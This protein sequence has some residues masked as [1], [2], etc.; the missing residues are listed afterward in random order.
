M[1]VIAALL[2]LIPALS[3][4]SN[5]TRDQRW[6]DDLQFLQQ[7]ITATHPNP[8]TQISR[9]QF[10]ESVQQ[11]NDTIPQLSDGAVIAGLA[12]IAAS[13][14]DYHTSLSLTQG[15]AGFRFPPIRLRWFPDGLFVTQASD[16]HGPSIGKRVVQIGDK[17]AEDAYAAVRPYI[18]GENDWW[19]RLI[20]GNYLI[21]PDILL[22]AGVIAADGPVP[23]VFEDGTA[24]NVALAPAALLNGPVI[25]KPLFPYYRRNPSQYYWYDYLP[26]AQTVYIKYNACTSM[27]TLPFS[28]FLTQMLQEFA[29]TQPSKAVIDMRNNGGGSSAVLQ[30]MI[31]AL[32]VAIRQGFPPSKLFVVIGRETASSASLNAATLKGLGATLIGE[33]VGGGASGFGEVIQFS[34][35]NSRLVVNCSSRVFQ[36]P[37]APGPTIAPDV[38]FELK[39][40]DY[41]A[42]RDPII[43]WILQ[44]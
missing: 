38:A 22:T 8:Y 12:K 23:F 26:E 19:A 13:I 7:R 11:L 16:A 36:I 27:N 41:F 37:N 30:P 14:G 17:P 18:S 2:L 43:E 25:A 40:S 20:S 42:D 32:Q 21:S 29:E 10:A 44:Q 15:T 24:I 4:Q 28:R 9:E 6:R 39:A 1:G 34:L 31:D 33:P 5:A 35:P 3:A